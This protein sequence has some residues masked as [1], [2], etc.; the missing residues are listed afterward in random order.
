MYHHHQSTI[1]NLGACTLGLGGVVGMGWGGFVER[2]VAF[3]FPFSLRG[4]GELNSAVL[5]RWLHGILRLKR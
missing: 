5:C 3:F 2:F 4:V 1:M